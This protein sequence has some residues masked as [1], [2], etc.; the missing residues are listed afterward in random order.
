MKINDKMKYQKLKH[1]IDIEALKTLA[2]LTGN[3][4]K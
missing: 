2:L 1:D 4:N 3:F